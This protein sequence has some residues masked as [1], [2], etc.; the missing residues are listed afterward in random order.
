VHPDHAAALASRL[1]ATLAGRFV[2]RAVLPHPLFL[3]LEF[4]AGETLGLSAEPEGAHLGLC[5]WGW[6]RGNPPQVVQARLKGVRIAS[7]SALPGEPLL[8]LDLAGGDAV[9]WEGLGRSANLVL[10]DGGGHVL[11]ASR[12]LKGPVRNG[13]P[14]EMWVPPPPRRSGT[15]IPA[16]P[17]FDPAAYLSEE[18][19][20]LLRE[21]LAARG[22]QEA[23]ALLDREERGLLRSLAAVAAERAEGEDWSRC[24]ELGRALLTAGG[25]DRRGL[26]SLALPD[27]SGPEPREVVIPLDPA[28]SLR[29]NADVFFKRVR[30]GK[31]RLEKTGARLAELETRR[32]TLAS[33]REAVAA[34]D[35]LERLFPARPGRT[36]GAPRPQRRRDLPSDVAAVPL[37]DGFAGYAGKSAAGNDRVSFRL[38]RG[39]DVWLHASDYPGCHVVVRNPARLE[40][41][42]PAVERAAALYAARHSGAPPGNRVAVLVSRCKFLRRVPGALGRVALSHSRTVLVELPRDGC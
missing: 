14:G 21:R 12:H 20:S 39:E 24:S 32:T 3:G 7:V 33:R 23:L 8:R 1:H 31:A 6:P 40:Q 18:G 11:W 4:G 37:P 29:Q 26:E 19:P 27:Y 17:P 42:P 5:R 38:G 30:R 36:P 15:P 41:L 25:L 28:L 2:R 16:P 10:L 22:R 35:D 13:S 34:E 9:V